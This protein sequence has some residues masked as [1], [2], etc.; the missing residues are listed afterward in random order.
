MNSVVFYRI[1]TSSSKHIPFLLQ[2]II[3]FT[4]GFTEADT[5]ITTTQNSAVVWSRDQAIVSPIKHFDRWIFPAN[6]KNGDDDVFLPSVQTEP[7][8]TTSK[9]CDIYNVKNQIKG[10]FI[11]GFICRISTARII[12]CLLLYDMYMGF[13]G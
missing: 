8:S 2:V 10:I 5:G 12:A 4:A 6:S 7:D 13:E 11:V 9:N 3:G 1:S